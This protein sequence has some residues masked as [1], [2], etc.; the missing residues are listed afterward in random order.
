MAERKEVKVE[1]SKGRV[2]LTFHLTFAANP[3]PQQLL[4][5]RVYDAQLT[6]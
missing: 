4:Y 2:H 5:R 6:R 3:M 1:L